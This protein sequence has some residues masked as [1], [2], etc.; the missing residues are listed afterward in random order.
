MKGVLDWKPTNLQISIF[1]GLGFLTCCLTQ[2]IVSLQKAP[3]P[4]VSLLFALLLPFRELF[5]QLWQQIAGPS[6]MSP[7]RHAMLFAVIASSASVAVFFPAAL[8]FLR[9]E[10]KPLHWTGLFLMGILAI[11]AILWFRVPNI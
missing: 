6:L 4:Y 2:Y 1:Y 10:K 3:S 11:M 8:V 5:R 7:G 9:S